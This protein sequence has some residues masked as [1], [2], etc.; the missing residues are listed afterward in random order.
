M[1]YTSAADSTKLLSIVLLII[2]ASNVVLVSCQGPELVYRGTGVNGTHDRA[3]S[4]NDTVVIGGLFTVHRNANNKCGRIRIYHIQYLE[5]MILAIHNINSNDS[6]LPGVTLAYEIRDTCINTNFALEQTLHFITEERALGNGKRGSVSGVIG[7]PFSFT[8]V[9]VANLLRLFQIPQISYAASA[10]ELSDKSRYDY[11]LR[12]SAPD[13]LQARAIADIIINFNWTYII[14]IH[15]DD[16]Y[17]KGGITS[18]IN[19]LKSSNSSLHIC[20][21]ATIAVSDSTDYDQIM[22]SIDQEWIA[23]SSVIVLFGHIANAEA[24]FEAALRREAVNKEFAERNITWIGSSSWGNNEPLQYNR[25]IHGLLS[26]VVEVPPNKEFEDHFLSLH[27]S[28]NSANPWFN[29]YWEEM[30]NCSLGG[31]SDADK[32]DLDNQA[33]SQS[34][35]YDQGTFVSLTIDAVYAFAHAIHNMQQDHC[36]GG[37]GLCPEILEESNFLKGGAI[38][39]ELLLEYLYRVSFEGASAE[40]IEFDKNGDM[41]GSYEIINLQIDSNGHFSYLTVGRWDGSDTEHGMSLTFSRN[42]NIQWKHSLNGSDVPISVCSQPCHGGEYH[43]P[44][45]NKPECC[46]TCKQCEGARQVGDGFECHE[47][48][49]GYRPSE[50]KSTC[51]YIQPSFLKWSDPLAIVVIMLAILGIAATTFVSVV[52]FVY[53]RERIIKASSRELSTVLLCGIMLCYLLPFIYVAKPSPVLCAIRRFG[54]GFCFSVCFSSLLVKTN[55]IHRIFN[56]KSES[57]EAPPLISPQ[58]QLFITAVLVALQMA[59]AVVWLVVEKPSTVLVYSDFNTDLLC[60]ENPYTGFSVTLAYNFLLLIVTTYFAF[61]TRKVPQNFNEAKF[62]NITVYSLC[63]LWLAFIPMYF[64]STSVLRASFQTGALTI[65]IILTATICLCCLLAPK[66][67]FLFSN[68]KKQNDQSAS[69]TGAVNVDTFR[70][71]Q[72]QSSPCGQR[73]EPSKITQTVSSVY[74]N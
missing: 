1:K 22:E 37:R 13:S 62:I 33:L 16:T 17:G 8:S 68:K 58:S 71:D 74:G 46:W 19:E 32:C 59:I 15:S 73:S 39:G 12:T 51:I 4:N 21:T 27:P 50:N 11:F 44:V 66:V 43:Q 38:N 10:E 70:T 3:A 41:S 5:A 63:I 23:N 48:N 67:Y 20:I 31:R 53:N 42:V 35:L 40:R 54:I 69:G 30:F 9:A 61:R 47:C 34:M 6:F 7:T 25:L 65:A 64:V 36:P 2:S 55:R 29:E 28:N 60:G 18:L 24:L 14:A 49:L 45:V 26:T 52:F 56:R 57:I 72:K